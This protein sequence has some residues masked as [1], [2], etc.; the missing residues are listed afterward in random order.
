MNLSFLICKTH[1]LV[2]CALPAILPDVQD[3]SESHPSFCIDLQTLPCPVP[4]KCLLS[5]YTQASSILTLMSQVCITPWASQ[6]NVL[7][8]NLIACVHSSNS[9]RRLP[10]ESFSPTPPLTVTCLCLN[11]LI[12]K[13]LKQVRRSFVIRLHAA[14]SSTANPPIAHPVPTPHNVNS[15]QVTLLLSSVYK[16]LGVFAQAW[17]TPWVGYIPKVLDDCIKLFV[18]SL[19]SSTGHQYLNAY[20][21]LSILHDSCLIRLYAS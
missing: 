7:P 1:F 16:H 14:V 10:F 5:P 3:T 20:I 18:T 9:S 4:L 11:F 6:F 13:N 2:I 8:T 15:S 12:A 21:R 17:N 19:C